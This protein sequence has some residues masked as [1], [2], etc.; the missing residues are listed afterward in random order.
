MFST[1]SLTSDWR[2]TVGQ[3]DSPVVKQAHIVPKCLLKGFATNGH[4]EF[5]VDGRP[6]PGTISIEDAATRRYFY[7]RHL[8][9]GSPTDDAEQGLQRVEDAAAPL[10]TQL[11]E[12]WDKINLADK[13]RLAEFFA[14]Q[15]VRGPR[16]K[17]WFEQ[18]VR[19]KADSWR[20]YPEPVRHNRLWI[21]MTQRFINHFEDHLLANTQWLM[22][23]REMS[24]KVM[25]IFGSM[26]WTLLEFQEPS[27]VLADHPVVDWPIA[28]DFRRPEPNRA[29][30]GALN[31]LEVRVPIASTRAILMTWSDEP[32]LTS[33]KPGTN[34]I[35]ANLNAF[36]I[37]NSERQ[38]VWQPESSPPVVSG[39]LEP[40]SP[41][42][43]LGYGK[44]V[45]EG[46]AL[47][48][49]VSEDLQPK[50]GIVNEA[51]QVDVFVSDFV[52]LHA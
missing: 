16:W 18:Q 47:R 20:R 13:G 14:T 38:W 52:H 30:I 3:M 46:S 26:K 45:A 33:R 24:L 42:V 31:F 29:G 41:R 25:A 44:R 37:A 49:A 4:L 22:R 35:A 10:L 39:Y 1:W 51:E 5:A 17:W 28:A 32:G 12:I 43:I 19:A 9:D 40:I 21:P 2:S 48:N 23:M 50:L 27:L 8:P 11:P 6:R 15:Y 7:R 36:S 34:E